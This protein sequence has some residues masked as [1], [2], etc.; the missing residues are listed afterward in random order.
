[1]SIEDSLVFG[2]LE[3]RESNELGK[4]EQ[5]GPQGDD[6]LSKQRK[7]CPLNT[8]GNTKLFRKFRVFRG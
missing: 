7:N 3:K 2:L 1:M 4:R 6:A 5:A 8:P